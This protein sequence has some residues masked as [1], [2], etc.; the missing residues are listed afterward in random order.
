MSQYING[1]LGYYGSDFTDVPYDRFEIV[2]D[3][4]EINLMAG[5]LFKVSQPYWH[6][7]LGYSN[8]V[9]DDCFDGSPDGF[10]GSNIFCLYEGCYRITVRGDR[11]KAVR[12]GN[13]KE[14]SSLWKAVGNLTYY[15]YNNWGVGWDSFFLYKI[16]GYKHHI[17]YP[18]HEYDCY[19]NERFLFLEKD[20]EF[21][22]AILNREKWVKSVDASHLEY[23]AEME[24]SSPDDLVFGENVG[25]PNIK[26]NKAGKYELY[27]Y[28][29][30]SNPTDCK[31][32][33][34]RSF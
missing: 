13:I 23:H 2:G 25:G 6:N 5:D 20:D 11:I 1:R 8:L 34:S 17:A 33:W 7:T 30:K 21:K 12:I 15:P 27:V 3:G 28:V 19:Y 31:V 10:G 16:P 22:L 24:G 26:V 18:E 9:S 4:I 29:S 32:L 14:E